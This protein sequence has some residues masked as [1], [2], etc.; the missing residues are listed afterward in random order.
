VKLSLGYL[1]RK[2][3]RRGLVDGDSVW[4]VVGGTALAL[5]LALKV[6]RKREEVVF[7]EKLGIGESLIIT[8][9]SP[10]GNNGRREGPAAQPQA[11]S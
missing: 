5:Q 11:R 9:R 7:S 6:V 4:L 10:T 3:L 2:G 8:H 1:V